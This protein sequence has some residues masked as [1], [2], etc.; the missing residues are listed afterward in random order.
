M[1]KE[2]DE[3][4][5]TCFYAAD[6]KAKIEKS[7]TLWAS[8]LDPLKYRKLYVKKVNIQATP[9]VSKDSS[10]LIGRDQ[11]LSLARQSNEDRAIARQYQEHDIVGITVIE[12]S[13]R[14]KTK[15]NTL[16][17]HLGWQ[18]HPVVTVMQGFREHLI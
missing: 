3:K 13:N 14:A 1:T 7:L 11:P 18:E 15:F 12:V 8:N 2:L 16:R 9:I 6:M 4:P 17:T 5:D 10:P